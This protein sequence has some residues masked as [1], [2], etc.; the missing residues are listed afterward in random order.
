MALKQ[1]EFWFVV[2]SQDLYGDDVLRQVDEHSRVMVDAWNQ[3]AS[4][5]G[6]VV[7]KPVV[8]NS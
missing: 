7:W 8:R 2:G 4:I 1:Y 6:T 5:P 3:D